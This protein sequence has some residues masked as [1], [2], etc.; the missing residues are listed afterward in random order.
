M[1]SIDFHQAEKSDFEPAYELLRR[2]F[3][4]EGFNTPLKELRS[5]LHQMIN[6]PASAV[7]LARVDQLPAGVA[8]V[9]TSVGLEYGLSAEMEDLYVLPDQRGAGIAST[10]I[11]G[12]CAWCSQRGVKTILVTVTP[13]GDHRHKLVDFYQ[14]RCFISTGR[15]LMERSLEAK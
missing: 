14:R 12:V 9:T 10:L 4:E 13:E 1:A 2:F 5:N 3:Q 8:T 6:S 7:F 15:Q 11:E